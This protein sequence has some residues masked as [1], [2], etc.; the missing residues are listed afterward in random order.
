MTSIPPFYKNKTMDNEIRIE[1]FLQ[2]DAAT[3]TRTPF[4]YKLGEVTL[5][6]PV[7][8][9]EKVVKINPYI[10]AIAKQDLDDLQSY[11]ENGKISECAAFIDKYADAVMKI[12]HTVVGKDISKKATT[13]DYMALLLA[14]LYRIHGESFLKSISLIQKLSLQTKA[15]IIAAE[16]RYMTSL[17]Y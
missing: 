4:E 10:V 14:T 8:T 6:V 5:R 16:K 2:M 1:D 11:V 17:S 9:M 3:I 13:D 7:L 12:V 15:G